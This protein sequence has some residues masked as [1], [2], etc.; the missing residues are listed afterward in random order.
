MFVSR[1]QNLKSEFNDQPWAGKVNDG[2]FIYTAANGGSSVA[3]KTADGGLRSY[4]GMTYAGLKSMIYAGLTPDDPRVKAALAYITKHYSVD[5]NPGLGQRGLYYYYQTFAKALAL[6]GK[7]TFVDPIGQG[8]RLARRPGRRPGQA[9]E[10]QRELG[11]PGRP[12]HGRRPQPRD[13]LRPARPGVRPAEGLREDCM[14]RRP[15][16]GRITS[17]RA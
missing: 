10:R 12:L 11:Q 7:P 1:C 2:G 4:A 13:L 3:G 5:E 6:L 15:V 8:A 9:A 17:S 14:T 16:G